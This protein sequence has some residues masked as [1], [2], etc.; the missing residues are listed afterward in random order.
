VTF[1]RVRE[2]RPIYV[3]DRRHLSHR[4]VSLGMRPPLAVFTIYLISLGLGLGAVGLADASAVHA[5]I[6]LV[7]SLAV[8]AIVLILLFYESRIRPPGEMQ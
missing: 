7:Q 8:V 2:R 4:L 3:G 1:I 6:I 5:V